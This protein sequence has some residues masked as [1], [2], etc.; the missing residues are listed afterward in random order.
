MVAT[1]NAPEAEERVLS[2]L[3]RDGSRRVMRPKLSKGHFYRRRFVTAWALIATF[4]LIPILRLGGKPLMLLDV[5]KREFTFFGATFL[6][7]DT[8]LLMLLLFS[9]FIGIFLITAVLGRVWCGW[10]CPQTVYMEFVYR[11]L[12]ILIEGGRKRQLELDAQGPDGRRILKYAVFLA[13]SAFLANTFLAYFVG[14]DRLL[15]WMSGSPAAHPGAFL[16]MAGT[17][18]LMFFD[19]AYFREQT[20]IVAC[21]YGRFQSV[22]LDR[23]S[24]IVGYDAGRGEPKAPW[25][26]K[27]ERAAGDCIDCKLCVSACPTGIDIRDGLQME[28]IHCTQCIDACDEVMDRIGLDRGLVRYTSQAE[29]ADGK[30]SFLRPRVVIYSAILVVMLGAFAFS[31]AGK[32]AADVTLLRGL[33][34]PFTILPDGRVSNQIRIK[35]ANRSEEERSYLIELAGGSGLELIAP[36]NPLTVASGETEMTA[37]FITAPPSAFSDGE[38][39]VTLTI[40]NGIDFTKVLDYR[41]LGPAARGNGFEGSGP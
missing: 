38:A 36:E 30:R 28:C 4:T 31:L 26:K 15:T 13:V 8:F 29:L 41:I 24:L 3:N 14:W 2:T 5:P 37:A 19:F 32:S 20:C 33:G 23:R 21:P 10:A 12:E 16:L 11:P 9:I 22:L 25:R 34:A 39:P 35:I 6:P 1:S 17:T 18:A 40:G 27:E 7:T